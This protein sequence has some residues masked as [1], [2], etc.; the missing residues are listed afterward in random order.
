MTAATFNITIDQGSDYVTKLTLSEDGSP[1]PLVGYEARAQ[2]REKKTSTTV[3]A[4]FDCQILDEVNGVLKFGLGN[5]ITQGIAPG[6]YYYDLEVYTPSEADVT[7]LLEGT[8]TVTQEV[9]R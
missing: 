8:A 5:A 3:T 2:M 7:R 6:I 1:K 4:T 9:T